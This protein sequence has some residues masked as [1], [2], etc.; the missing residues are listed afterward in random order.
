MRI[1]EIAPPWFPVPPNGYGGIE[2]IVAHLT[3]GLVERGH[4]VTLFASGGSSTRARHVAPLPSPPDP[5]ALG[6]PAE[7]V[8]HAFAAYLEASDFDVIHDHS[9]LI[10]PALGAMLASRPPIVHTLHG[11]WTEQ[12]RRFYPLIHKRVN[13][14][15]ISAAQRAQNTAVDYAGVVH[16]AIDPRAFRFEDRKEPFLTFLGRSSPD[17]GPDRA[18]RIA[19]RAGRRLCMMVKCNEPAEVDYWRTEVEPLLGPDVQVIPD[20]THDTKV[21][22]LSRSQALLFPIAWEEPFGL[23]MIE[24]MACG[25]PVIATARGSVPE[26]VRHGE[27]G[28]H[29]DPDHIVESAVELLAGIHKLAPAA[30]RSWAVAEFSVE[31]MVDGYERIFGSVA[32]PVAAV[33]AQPELH[34]IAARGDGDDRGSGAPALIQL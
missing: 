4:D 20:A 30:C 16:N 6:D 23:A 10:G 12:A 34:A 22:M 33:G 13:L 9:G 18:I 19:R 27:T 17:K 25:T 32:S 1:A 2:R 15:A 24:A 31:K 14:V 26:I 28:F 8:F 11:P 5:R 21:E 3:D 7:D 29:A